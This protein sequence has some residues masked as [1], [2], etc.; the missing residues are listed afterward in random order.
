[1]AKLHQ[2]LCACLLATAGLCFPLVALWYVVYFQF[3]AWCHHFVQWAITANQILLN[4]K[5]QHIMICEL[6]AKSAICNSLFAG[7][8]RRMLKKRKKR[9]KQRKMLL[10]EWN[11]KYRRTSRMM[12]ALLRVLWLVSASFV[13]LHYST[14]EI[15]FGQILI[16][17]V[18]W[19]DKTI[20]S[21]HLLIHLWA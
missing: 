15:Q 16:I 2:I 9:K 10:R 13:C 6:G 17:R 11:R 21:V 4:S 7:C 20:S 1:M 12:S 19:E 14:T 5:D 3:C 8:R 18:S